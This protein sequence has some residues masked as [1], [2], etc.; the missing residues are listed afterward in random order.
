MSLAGSYSTTWSPSGFFSVTVNVL[1]S[2][3]GAGAGAAGAGAAAAAGA[4]AASFSRIS[5]TLSAACCT[6]GTLIGKG[7][8]HSGAC[9][10]RTMKEQSAGRW[11]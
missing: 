2:A 11:L 9:V 5:L 7:G 6:F 1:L 4:G 8:K 10:R 3:A